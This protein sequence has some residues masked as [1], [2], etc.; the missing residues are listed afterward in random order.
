MAKYKQVGPHKYCEEEDELGS[1]LP[2][3]PGYPPEKKGC[4]GGAATIVLIV[5]C[6]LLLL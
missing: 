3:G 2:D 4:L 5:F 6:S 1:N